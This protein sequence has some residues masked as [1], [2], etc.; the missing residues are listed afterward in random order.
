MTDLLTLASHAVDGE[1]DKE[2]FVARVTDFRELG[3]IDG[4]QLYQIALDRSAFTSDRSRGVLIA[5]SRNGL[6]LE[7][8]VLAVERDPDGALWHTTPKPLQPG[9]D[10]RG[11]LFV[12]P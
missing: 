1:V 8:E 2:E 11:R 9:V 4:V 10:V 7:A 12:A 3:R 6:T 5:M